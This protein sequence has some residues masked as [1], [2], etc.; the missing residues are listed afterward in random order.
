MEK[1]KYQVNVTFW[2]WLMYPPPTGMEKLKSQVNVTF[3]FWLMYPLPPGMEKLKS[4]VNVT[5]WFLLMYPPRNQ[6][7]TKHECYR[8]KSFQDRSSSTFYNLPTTFQYHYLILCLNRKLVN[9]NFK[10]IWIYGLEPHPPPL[11]SPKKMKCSFWI[12]FNF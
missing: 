7:L 4:Q 8:T 10:W 6:N 1:L 9:F 2:F 11:T 12:M 3:W 5:F